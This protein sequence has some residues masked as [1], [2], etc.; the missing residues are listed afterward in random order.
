MLIKTK[1]ASAVAVAIA[2][3]VMAMP[4]NAQEQD[5][6][7]IVVTGEKIGRSVQQTQTSIEVLTDEELQRASAVDISDVFKRVAN[8]TQLSEGSNRTS[9]AIRG[10]N[11]FGEATSTSGAMTSSVYVDNAS[12]G[13]LTTRYGLP[14]MWDIAQIEFLRGPQSTIQ[15]RNSMF[16]SIIINSNDPTYQPEGKL[17]LSLGSNNNRR[18]SGAYSM[19]IIDDELAIRVALDRDESD[20]YVT[21]IT[22]G[23]D[24]YAG[25]QRNNAR[26]KVLYEPQAIE[27]LSI[28]LSWNKANNKLKDSAMVPKELLGKYQAVSDYA[29]L[30]EIESDSTSL[31]IN[32]QIN[33]Q[34]SLTAVSGFSRGD[35]NRQDDYDSSAMPGNTVIQHDN[36]QAFSQELRFFYQDDS[37][38]AI[39]GAFYAN[40]DLDTQYDIVSIAPKSLFQDKII[41]GAM[42]AGGLDLAQATAFYQQVFPNTL[43]VAASNETT[44]S[45]SNVAIFGEIDWRINPQ[46]QL[47][48]GGRYDREKQNRTVHSKV[49][50]PD[51]HA[52]PLVQG[53]L[54]AL[55]I[56]GKVD[57][58]QET[59]YHAFLPKVSAIY[60]INDQ[61]SI[62]ANIQRSYRAGGISVNPLNGD[63]ITFD[64]EFAWNY[65]LAHR[66]SWLNGDLTSRTNVYLTKLT[67]QQV[68]V[69]LDSTGLNNAN[70]NA[71]KSELYGFELAL[72]Y[73]VSNEMALYTS[74]GYAH[75][76]YSEFKD[77]VMVNGKPKAIKDLTG[78]QFR[79]APAWNGVVG[80][81]YDF[82]EGWYANADVSYRGN[83]WANS[84]NT[85]E[86]DAYT[87]V[88]AKVGYRSDDDWQVSLSVQNLTDKLYVS[89]VFNANSAIPLKQDNYTVG[90]PRTVL[91]NLQYQF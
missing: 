64:P 9:F 75:T 63:V 59:T 38:S 2:L 76:E 57:V 22:R 52:H 19:P 14:S 67:D 91:L 46:W 42:Y 50:S 40:I 88:N 70:I 18:L 39:V 79:R 11:V 26:I 28:L 68:N 6:E 4:L 62:S 23:E 48:V 49:S 44:T 82:A 8:V 10:M 85:R 32:Y 41:G 61:Q 25:H 84:E 33:D 73:N 15:G 31:D 71:G 77:S 37:V 43:N 51:S 72:N 81:E 1:I 24:D 83:A 20:G 27:D 65:E 58:P 66:A 5:V 90:A 45:M 16:G 60:H 13:Q 12:V 17:Q 56:E 36:E 30:F 7:R 3:N 34:W 69:A 89:N 54:S 53:L 74:I 86:L 55:V 21:N 47:I 78:K 80:V 87:L 29:A 35:F